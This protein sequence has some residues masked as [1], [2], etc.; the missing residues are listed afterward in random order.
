MVKMNSILK[1]FKN[2]RKPLFGN[3]KP[4]N[5]RLQKFYWHRFFAPLIISCLF[6]TRKILRI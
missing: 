2:N 6:K 1:I 5:R 3:K 4:E